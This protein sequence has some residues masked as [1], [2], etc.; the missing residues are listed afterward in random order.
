MNHSDYKGRVQTADANPAYE[1]FWTM[2]SRLSA[3]T[4]FSRPPV[5]DLVLALLTLA[6]GAYEIGYQTA[7]AVEALR[8]IASA[9]GAENEQ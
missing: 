8:R 6:G 1:Q 9:L 5:D 2:R 7:R 4:G 3:D